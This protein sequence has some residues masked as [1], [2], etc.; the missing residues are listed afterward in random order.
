MVHWYVRDVLL[1]AAQSFNEGSPIYY[2]K[3]ELI[4]QVKSHTKSSS[5]P[6]PSPNCEKI[7]HLLSG[8]VSEWLRYYVGKEMDG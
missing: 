8:V 7:T 5:S 6:Q 3:F 1:F 4:V 2:S